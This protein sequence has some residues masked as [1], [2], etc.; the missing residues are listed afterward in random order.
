LRRSRVLIGIAVA[1]SII[2]ALAVVR[3]IAT[4]RAQT[5]REVSYRAAVESY[6]ERFGAGVSRADVERQLRDR[7]VE[8]HQVGGL[9]ERTAYADLVKI[10]EEAVPWF[11]SE[12]NVYVALH[13]A[14]PDDSHP[15]DARPSDVLKRVTLFKR[16][17]GCL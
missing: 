15:S 12:H 1:V 3:F 6:A 9:E 11:C 17:E 14:A 13:F 16:L 5:V 2:A 7:G 8:F 4:R 10:G